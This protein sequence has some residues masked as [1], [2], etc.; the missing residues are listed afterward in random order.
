MKHN[1][2][3][4]LILLVTVMCPIFTSAQERKMTGTVVD[5]ETGK[6]IGGATVKLYDGIN[7]TSTDAKGNF[8]INMKDIDRNVSIH[9]Y[10]IGYRA[11]DTVLAMGTKHRIELY[12]AAIGIDEVLVSTGYDALPRERATGSFALIGKERINEQINFN[13]MDRLPAVAS[14]LMVDHNTKSGKV[15]FLVRGMSTIQGETQPLIVLDNFP[16]EG[17]LNSINPDD[18]QNVTIL[19][20]AAAASIWGARAGNGVIVITTKKG[21]ANQKLKIDLNVLTTIQ[22]KPDLF[23]LDR[24]SSSDMID[25]ETSLFDKGYYSASVNS[26]QRPV[27]SPIVELLIQKNATQDQNEITKID[28]EISR[29]RDVDVR[30]DFNKYLYRLGVQ[31]Q[32]TVGLSQGTDRLIWNASIGNGLQIDHLDNRVRRNNVLMNAKV[33]LTK[34]LTLDG[35]MNISFQNLRSGRPGYGSVNAYNGGLYPYAEFAD[36][37]GN[38]LPVLKDWRG[39]YLEQ[40]AAEGLLDWRYYPLEDYKHNVQTERV[41]NT[42]LSTALSYKL[43][44]WF[45]LSLRYQYQSQSGRMDKLSDIESYEARNM[46]NSNAVLN[47][48]T[49]KVDFKIPKGG[50]FDQSNS[51]LSSHNVRGQVDFNW[52]KTQHKVYALLGS[53]LRSINSNGNSTR[54]YGYNKDNLS[55]ALFDLT[56]PYTHYITGAKNY[57][58]DG[59]SINKKQDRF[60]STFLNASYSFDDRYMAT[61]SAR[62]DASNLFGLNVKDKW[63]PFWSAGIGWTISNEK[64]WNPNTISYLKLRGT[65]GKTGNLNPAMVALTTIKYAGPNTYTQTPYARFENYVNPELKWESVST[66]N[67][68]LD[69]ALKNKRISG[70]LEGYIK[71]GSNLYGIAPLDYTSGI[72]PFVMKN[73]AAMQGKG[74][75]LNLNSINTIGKLR[76]SSDLNLSLNSDKITKYHMETTSATQF[77]SGINLISGK[78]GSPVYSMYSYKWMGLDPE[79]GAALGLLDGQPSREYRKFTGTSATVDDLVF[80]GGILPKVFGSFGNTIA[81]RDWA[82]TMRWTFK[83]D[84]YFRRETIRYSSLF[85]TW[86][87]HGDFS[88]RWQQPGDEKKSDIPAMFYPVLS[89][90][91]NFYPYAEPFVERGDHVRFEYLN[92]SYRIKGGATSWLKD[93]LVSL[94]VNNLGLIYRKNKVGI[95]PDFSKSSSTGFSPSKIYSFNIKCSL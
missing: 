46:V 33:L 95:D 56:V 3:Y 70:T 72:G 34:S 15:Q 36:N 6:A 24:I 60:I 75:D 42:I 19:R 69:F 59:L 67:I 54:L 55:Y 92:L 84:Y 48:S 47:T 43:P 22:Q 25:V 4:G 28:R 39:M 7:R 2:I 86:N 62:R 58:M 83:F 12:A 79:D 26:A 82:L 64:Y 80:H 41:Q 17:D 20:D 13:I 10:A 31:Q 88:K 11:V 49:G 85:S 94:N 76:W 38:A 50:I 71:K 74:L 90:A 29:L 32:T 91:E 51:L 68:G 63:N 14:G 66:V 1:K 77:I 81:W 35:G 8:E 61:F 93:V 23:S 65:Y 78:E 27:L 44:K 37:E 53:E 89:G 52:E 45:G 21:T 73:V 9:V 16:F 5:L 40:Q 87:G 30:N 57:V 18:I